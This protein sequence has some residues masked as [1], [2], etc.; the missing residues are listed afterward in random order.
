MKRRGVMVLLWLLCMVAL[1]LLAVMQ[2]LQG[3]FGSTARSLAMA[4]AID[5]CGNALFGGDPTMTISARTGLGFAEGLRW[6]KV[7]RPVIDALFGSGHC[8]AEAQQYR[9]KRRCD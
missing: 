4:T 7:L 8:A 3:L 9:D 5:Q 2:L 1:P 6:A